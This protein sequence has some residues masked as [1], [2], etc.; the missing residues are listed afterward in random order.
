MHENI[1]FQTHFDIIPFPV[2]AIDIKKFEIMFS[3]QSFIKLFG[4]HKGK[5]CY[6][7][8]YS[9]DAP[10][11]DCNIDKLLDADG[12]PNGQTLVHELFH[13]ANQSWYHIQDKI[14]NW[15]DGRV[16]KY[17]IAVDITELKVI[18]NQLAEAH[19]ELAIK[20]RELESLSTTDFLTGINNRLSMQNII[21]TELARTSRHGSSASL[22]FIDIDHFKSIND[23]YGHQA[24][25]DILQAFAKLIK[26]SIRKIDFIGRWGGEEFVVLCPETDIEQVIII[27]RK[28]LDVIRGH[29]F[30][31]AGNIRASIGVSVSCSGDTVETL[32]GRAD[33]ALYNAKESGRDRYEIMN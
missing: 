13:E 19:A 14:I 22:L 2:Y 12:K 21:D 9:Y 8:L 31:V 23:N 27:V 20:N 1:L 33:K 18:Q 29:S 32:V 17:S 25:D 26:T 30:P 10:C 16:V 28:I 15:P 4:E 3:N 6:K 7:S 5:K 11:K 24:G